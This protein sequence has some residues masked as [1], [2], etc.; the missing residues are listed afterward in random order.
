V[1]PPAVP[2]KTKSIAH[3][4]FAQLGAGIAIRGSADLSEVC[5][6]FAPFSTRVGPNRVQRLSS[7]HQTRSGSTP[8]L[9]SVRQVSY[10]LGVSTAIVYRLCERGEL[11][12]L[13]VRHAIRVGLDDLAAYLKRQRPRP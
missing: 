5:H 3:A 9:L 10:L 13:R 1:R 8:V 11:G 6:A 4:S 2:S 7:E 12:H